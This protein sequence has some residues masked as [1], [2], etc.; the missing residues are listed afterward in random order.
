MQRPNQI[1]HSSPW[2]DLIEAL[3]LHEEAYRTITDTPSTLRPQLDQLRQ[4]SVKLIKPR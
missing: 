3:L 1:A 2:F 4:A